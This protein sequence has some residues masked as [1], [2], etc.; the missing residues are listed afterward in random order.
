ML[1][2]LF[3][4]IWMVLFGCFIAHLLLD[5][6]FFRSYTVFRKQYGVF[7]EMAV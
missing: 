5:I 2:R 6:D 3:S 1:P 7:L 4:S